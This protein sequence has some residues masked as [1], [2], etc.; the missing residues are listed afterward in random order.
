MTRL[1]NAYTIAPNNIQVGDVMLFTIKAMVVGK[2]DGKLIYRLY[3]CPCD[4]VGDIP[5]GS[6]IFNNTADICEGLFMSLAVVGT[7]DTML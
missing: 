5:Q 7:P 6:R 1:I 2:V 4:V 3:R